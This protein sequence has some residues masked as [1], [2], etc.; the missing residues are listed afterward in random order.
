MFGEVV[1][2]FVGRLCLSASGITRLFFISRFNECVFTCEL[3]LFCSSLPP[4]IFETLNK[5]EVFSG[6]GG[7][8]FGRWYRKKLEKLLGVVNTKFDGRLETA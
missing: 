1:Q 7:C 3:T 2:R 4:C 8:F 5:Q 6:R